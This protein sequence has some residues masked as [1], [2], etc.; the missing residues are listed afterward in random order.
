MEEE[1]TCSRSAWRRVQVPPPPQDHDG[2]QTDARVLS[3]TPT[4]NAPT[5]ACHAATNRCIIRLASTSGTRRTRNGIEL[6][7]ALLKRGYYGTY[8]QMSPKHLHRYVAEFE[9]RHNLRLLDTIDQI[10]ALVRGMD[11][12]RLRYVDLTTP[13]KSAA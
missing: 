1:G 3:S 4:V 5:R 6:F 2:E 8:H 7:W 11:Q 10:A 9:G 13:V 12:K